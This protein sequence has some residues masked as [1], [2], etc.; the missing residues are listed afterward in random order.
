MR[1]IEAEVM[2]HNGNISSATEKINYVREL[3]NLSPKEADSMD[4]AWSILRQERNITLWMEGRRLWDLRRFDDPFLQDRDS[5][6]P[7]GQQE[8]N[9]NPNIDS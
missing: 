8:I 2:L 4:E 5:C 9:T 1:L 7:P 6:I 3:F